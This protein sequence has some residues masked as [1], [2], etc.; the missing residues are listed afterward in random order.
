[1]AGE[2][3]QYR[4]LVQTLIQQIELPVAVETVLGMIWTESRGDRYALRYEPHYRWLFRPEGMAQELGIPV[5]T[6]IMQQRVSWGLLQLMGANARVLG[7]RAPYLSCLVDPETNLW[8]AF[9]FLKTLWKRYGP[10]E[11]DVIA[12]YN[13]GQPRKTDGRYLNQDYVDK[14]LTAKTFFV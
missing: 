4:E 7:C 6:E 5:V 13:A 3:A 8:Y 12:A 2:V 11:T 1:M 14:V 9:R 10:E